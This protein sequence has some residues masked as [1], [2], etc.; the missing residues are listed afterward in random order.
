[1]KA[2]FSHI[3]ILK[4]IRVLVELGCETDF[5]AKTEGFNDLAASIAMQVAASNPLAVDESGISQDI[6]D[7]EKEI[8]MD[9][10]KIRKA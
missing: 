5:V 1:M 6:L 2:L 7:K 3:F 8:F 10:A 4:Q 9:Q